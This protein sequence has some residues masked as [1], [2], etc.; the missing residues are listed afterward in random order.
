MK[1]NAHLFIRGCFC[2][3][4]A[5]TSCQPENK[6][7]VQGTL[8]WEESGTPIDGARVILALPGQEDSDN[9]TFTDSL[10]QFILFEN[11]RNNLQLKV[12]YPKAPGGEIAQDLL[13]GPGRSTHEVSIPEVG[14]F[15]PKYIRLGTSDYN[16]SGRI[17]ITSDNIIVLPENYNPINTW[18]DNSPVIVKGGSMVTFKLYLEKYNA[19]THE[20]LPVTLEDSVFIAT[21]Q[22]YTD[23]I[24]Y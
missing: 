4:L 17:E 2:L 8:V 21:L 20:Y 23:T 12:P 22:H 1:R 5:L 13:V 19:Q 15:N 11:S 24:Y 14:Y 7:I 6:F 10:G 9:Y 18:G 3:A 16:Y